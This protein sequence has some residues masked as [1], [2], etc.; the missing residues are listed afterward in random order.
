MTYMQEQ[1][2]RLIQKLPDN[3][4]QAFLTLMS[5]ETELLMPKISEEAEKKKKAFYALEHLELGLPN[6]F[7]A[8]KELSLALEEKYGTPD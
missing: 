6:G 3:K 5:D 7:D 2:I 8:E 1:A 4:I